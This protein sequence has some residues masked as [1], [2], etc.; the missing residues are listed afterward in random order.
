MNEILAAIEKHLKRPLKAS[1][2]D[3]YQVIGLEPFCTD[4][5]AIESALK[6]ALEQIR[7]SESSNPA[8]QENP[9]QTADPTGSLQVVQKLLRQA[10]S[11]LLDPS[12][13]TAYDSQLA[14]L[15]ESQKKQKELGK[16]APSR[17]Q[18]TVGIVERTSNRPSA[19]TSSP[20]I[21][22]NA[23][24]LLPMG[25]PMLPFNPASIAPDSFARANSSLNL[26][27]EKR[28]AELSEL[29]PSLM[30][31]SIQPEPT[32]EQPP[33]WLVAADRKPSANASTRANPNGSIA[34]KDQLDAAKRSETK[35][36]ETNRVDLVEQL[37]SRRRRRNLLAVGGM[38]LAALGLLGFASFRFLSNRQQVAQQNRN[39]PADRPT[40]NLQGNAILGADPS[41]AKPPDLKIG[42]STKGRNRKGP[43]ESPLPELPSVGF[44]T[45]DASLPMT[46]NPAM[47]KPP[48]QVPPDAP[49]NPDAPSNPEPAPETPPEPT[50]VPTAEPTPEPA[51]ANET[52]EW[53]AGM[54]KAKEALV[55]R[56]PSKFE[57][58]IAAM[59]DKATTKLGK[60][61]TAR[62]D[63]AGQ[64]LK[65]YAESF[66]EAKIKAKG[67]SSLKVGA[68]E[69]SIVE[70]TPE[71]LIIRAQGKNQSYEWDKLPFGIAA[72]VCDLGLSESAPVD[73]A[74]RAIFF[75]I[76][77]FYQEAAKSNN[78]VTKRID[79]WF[80]RSLG[81][82]SIR[83]DL[84]QFLTDR[85]E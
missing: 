82:E 64:L 85:Y 19:G 20:T 72:A 36:T 77:P 47:A 14:Q 1:Q 75:S 22:P 58:L 17:T 32:Q 76:H 46:D 74:A 60:D 73:I 8:T 9:S 49:G 71:K 23:S 84:K 7:T 78:L 34:D 51:M 52:P 37:R 40:E 81:K 59:L 29:F 61:Q 66:E 54:A 39:K 43:N 44:S 24:E 13:K 68:T 6:T 15:F 63:Q 65:I 16:N 31:M 80:E 11:I 50:P 28:R 41:N 2:L 79:G 26:T 38:V 4:K 3:Y 12:K 56:D 57:P 55:S 48:V 67:A 70:S 21:A 83:A 10:Q 5:S 18:A 69:V 35:S 25:D 62:L 30:L 33:A 42:A 27:P 53:K 45:P